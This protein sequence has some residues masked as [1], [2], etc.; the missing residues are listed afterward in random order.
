MTTINLNS[1][2]Q[3]PVKGALDQLANRNIFNCRFYSATSTDTT[4]PC[5]GVVIDDEYTGAISVAAA[6][7]QDSDFFGFVTW[8]HKNNA[9]GVGEFVEV[10]SDYCVM[11][12]EATATA[13]NAGTGVAY[14]VSGQKIEASATGD[15]IIGYALE[16]ISASGIGR[17][18][19]KCIGAVT[20]A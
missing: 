5:M 20:L 6:T 9:K 11:Y 12:M 10:A 1:T 15:K 8:N 13:I 14:V 17:V 4:A 3:V 19:I 7:A 2:F 18:L 16:D